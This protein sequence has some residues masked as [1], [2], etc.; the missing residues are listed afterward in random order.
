MFG[1]WFSVP[2][3]DIERCDFLLMLGAN[4]MASNGSLWTVPDFRGKARAMHARG[5]RLVVV[6]PRRT[7]TAAVADQHL[8]IRPGTDVFFLLGLV[9]TLF[10][11][12]LVRL[13][14]LAPHVAGLDA[15]R[16]AVA[17]FTPERMAARCGIAAATPARAG[18]FAGRQR[19]RRGVRP[20]R[21][22]HAGVRHAVQLAGGRAQCAGRATWTSRAAPCSP[23]RRRS[24]PTPAASPARAMAS[25]P[26][27][28]RAASRVRR[29]CWASSP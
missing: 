29:R 10:D 21:H 18:A 14:A 8:F 22:L 20:H 28:A 7:E 19:T 1:T 26:A 27:G 6:D 9:H 15:L 2:V 5:G 13:R 24:P 23:R 17:P 11:E 16:E 12:G 4:P 3:P 25:P